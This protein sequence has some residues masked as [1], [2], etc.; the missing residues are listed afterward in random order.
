MNEP[1]GKDKNGEPVYVG[2]YV[3][4]TD[5]LHCKVTGTDYGLA[6]LAP[7]ATEPCRYA[8][9]EDLTVQQHGQRAPRGPVGKDCAGNLVFENDVVKSDGGELWE[10]MGGNFENGTVSVIPFNGE[11]RMGETRHVSWCDVAIVYSLSPERMYR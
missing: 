1:L 3:T 6:R 7:I 9:F 10:V 2:D 4:F 8:T 11:K 5:E